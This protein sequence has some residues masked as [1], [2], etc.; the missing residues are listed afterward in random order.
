MKLITFTI[1]EPLRLGKVVGGGVFDLTERMG[2]H[3]VRDLMASGRLAEAEAIAGTSD[4]SVA[5]VQLGLPI[6]DPAKIFCIGVNYQ[7][8]NEEY[9]DGSEAPKYPSLFIRTPLSFVPHGGHLVI[10]HESEQLDYE[11]E[12]VLVI[13]K[14]G[15]RIAQAASG[16]GSRPISAASISTICA[17]K[18]V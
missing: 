15:R 14:A 5:D 1:G 7:N 8:R 10:P 2:L 3:S 11:G 6:P 17:W 16:H 9:K 18:R 4:H 13:G 12:I